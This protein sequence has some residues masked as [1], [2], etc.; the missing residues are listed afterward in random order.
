M[1]TMEHLGETRIDC[2]RNEV[3]EMIRSE[4]MLNNTMA[5]EMI[6][7]T[8]SQVDCT[9]YLFAASGYNTILVGS[10][11]VSKTYFLTF[12]LGLGVIFTGDKMKKS[13]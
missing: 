4:M 1:S 10:R 5:S 7:E 9:S 13:Q 12:E 6:I 2:M 3:F 8:L 11:D